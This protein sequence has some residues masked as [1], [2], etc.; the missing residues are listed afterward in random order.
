MQHY[1]ALACVMLPWKIFTSAMVYRSL[2][3]GNA[4]IAEQ[5]GR[6][7][8]SCTCYPLWTAAVS[9]SSGKAV[10]YLSMNPLTGSRTL[11]IFA[12]KLRLYAWDRYYQPK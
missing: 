6:N 11:M 1:Q 4:G 10:H 3:S 7:V 9:L 2:R 5:R 12:L 8:G